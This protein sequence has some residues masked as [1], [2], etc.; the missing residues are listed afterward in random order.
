MDSSSQLKAITRA[1]KFFF[2]AS[3]FWILPSVIPTMG[4]LYDI[5][6]IIYDWTAWISSIIALLFSVAAIIAISASKDS[7]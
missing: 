7:E 1:L 2:I 4:D 5:T 6:S 3:F